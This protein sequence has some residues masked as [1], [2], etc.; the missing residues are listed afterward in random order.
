M[1][2][3]NEIRVLSAD[4][5]RQA[6]PM[7]GAVETMKEAFEELSAGR[8]IMPAR[9]HVDVPAQ[10]GTTL[11]MPSYASRFGK[12]GVKVVSVF[13]GN[14]EKGL[15]VI[16]GIVC[17]LDGETG[18]PLAILDGTYLTALRTGAASGAATDLLA[19]A[20]A[21]TA[22]I[23]G[24]GVQGRTQL[25]AVCA[26]RSIRK[27][28]VYDVAQKSAEVFAEAMSTALSVEVIVASSARDAVKDADIVCAA[29]VS[30]T[31]V[32]ADADIAAGTHVN[33][34][35]S[36]KP[37]VQEIPAET[38]LRALVVVDHRESALAETG[39]LIIPIQQGRMG[40]T[41]IH[42]ELGEI[43]AGKA[44]GRTADSQVTLFKSVGVAIEDLAAG[45]RVL[46]QAQAHDL[47]QIVRL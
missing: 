34:V 29:T 33:A 36:Y 46:E 13:G 44:V 24:A 28:W 1:K 32:F 12:I 2:H 9:A 42:A 26:V 16:Q 18:T 43:V 4:D 20:D 39:D 47:G 10:A 27:V 5:I 21:T 7:A 6:L 38:V 40:A 19:R 11:F 30:S 22:A 41:D 35:G 8:V 37:E 14:R 31:P 3:T 23:L 17:L 15:P 45:A 25:E